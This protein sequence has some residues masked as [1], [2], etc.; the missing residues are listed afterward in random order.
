MVTDLYTKDLQSLVQKRD[1][2]V[3]A[4]HDQQMRQSQMKK[5]L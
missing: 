3:E 5:K 4:Q 1:A 2:E